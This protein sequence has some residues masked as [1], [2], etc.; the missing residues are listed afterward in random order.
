MLPAAT[1]TAQI[2]RLATATFSLSTEESNAR[3]TIRY[4]RNKAVING[5]GRE[6]LALFP[7]INTDKDPISIVLFRNYSGTP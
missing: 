3:A 6:T 5:F 7:P 4:G 2:Q 1:L